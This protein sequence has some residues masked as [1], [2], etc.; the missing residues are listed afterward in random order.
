MT[1]WDSIP[2]P[3]DIGKTHL[4]SEYLSCNPKSFYILV[5]VAIIL[6]LLPPNIPFSLFFHWLFF[7][8]TKL[9][10]PLLDDSF[11]YS[12]NSDILILLSSLTYIPYGDNMTSLNIYLSW[13]ILKDFIKVLNTQS[14]F[15]FMFKYSTFHSSIFLR[16]DLQLPSNPL[17]QIDNLFCQSNQWQYMP[18]LPCPPFNPPPPPL[19]LPRHGTYF[20][21]ADC[22]TGI[23]TY[24]P[25]RS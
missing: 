25:L 5:Y 17:L 11:V 7:S 12:H 13:R 8:T 23:L 16:Q 22:P 15:L 2:M 18:L 20:S 19:T 10:N 6:N 21:S 14:L 3:V 1:F 24:P 4:I 9:F